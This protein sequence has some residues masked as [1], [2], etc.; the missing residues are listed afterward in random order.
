MR[1]N[2]AIAMKMYDFFFS[3]TEFLLFKLMIKHIELHNWGEMR[4]PMQ[5]MAFHRLQIY[6]ERI[7]YCIF[8]WTIKIQ[9]YFKGKEAIL[10]HLD[11]LHIYGYF[12]IIEYNW[13]WFYILMS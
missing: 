9:F 8:N 1:D 4:F 10:E 2:L 7:S 6:L 5:S 13:T 11:S 12:P 3:L